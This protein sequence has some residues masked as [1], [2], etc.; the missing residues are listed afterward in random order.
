MKSAIICDYNGGCEVS[1]I[2]SCR[3]FGSIRR[4]AATNA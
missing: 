2:T 3:E 4:T 1:D